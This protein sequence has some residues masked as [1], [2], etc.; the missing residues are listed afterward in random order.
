[1][2]FFK[3]LITSHRSADAH[4]EALTPILNRQSLCVSPVEVTANNRIYLPHTHS[5]G[6]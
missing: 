6:R 5:F 1:M 4:G 2:E 3:T